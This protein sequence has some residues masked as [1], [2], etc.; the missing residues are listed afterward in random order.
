MKAFPR[1]FV[2]KV[3]IAAKRQSSEHSHLE[4]YAV[5][6]SDVSQMPVFYFSYQVR[7][8]PGETQ[9]VAHPIDRP[10]HSPQA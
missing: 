7:S 4:F 10:A 1:N 3:A 9:L 2:P 5:I 8:L 6:H